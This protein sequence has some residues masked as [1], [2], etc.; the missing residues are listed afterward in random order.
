MSQRHPTLK[1]TSPTAN[2]SPSAMDNLMMS[3]CQT[4][5]VAGLK[6]TSHETD[7]QV[8]LGAKNDKIQLLEVEKLVGQLDDRYAE[9]SVRCLSIERHWILFSFD[10]FL[11]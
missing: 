9:L 6:T 4:T 7:R 2:P 3:Y 10:R 8:D 1:T 11:P 5:N